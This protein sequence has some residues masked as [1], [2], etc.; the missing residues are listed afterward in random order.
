MAEADDPHVLD[1]SSCGLKKLEKRDGV[2]VHK[3]VLDH[4]ELTKLE[5]VDCFIDVQKLSATN[6]QITRMYSVGRLSQL[7]SLDLSNNLIVGIEGL[8]D[9]KHLVWTSLSNNKIKSLQNIQYSTTLVYLDLSNNSIPSLIDLTSLTRLKTLLLKKNEITTLQ[10][11]QAYLPSGLCVFSV[12]ENKI[13]DLTEVS[14]LSHLSSLESFSISGN[15]CVTLTGGI[16]GFDYRPYVINWCLGLRVLDDFVVTQRESLKAEWLYSQGKGRCFH[17]GDHLALVEYL[18][19]VCPMTTADQLESE[20]EERISRVLRM[21]RQHREQLLHEMSPG[22]TAHQQADNNNSIQGNRHP[23]HTP[24]GNRRPTTTIPRSAVGRLPSGR[25]GGKDKWGELSASE[26]EKMIGTGI[27]PFPDLLAHSDNSPVRLSSRKS[28]VASSDLTRS[29]VEARSP[30][31]IERLNDAASTGN[32][33]GSS[34]HRR[35]RRDDIM[36]R[37]VPEFRSDGSPVLHGYG[38]SSPRAIPIRKVAS[39]RREAAAAAA[40]VAPTVDQVVAASKVLENGL[41][42]SNGTSRLQNHH[43]SPSDGGLYRSSSFRN[44]GVRPAYISSPPVT[45]SPRKTQRSSS[46]TS[47]CPPYS[48]RSVPHRNMVAKPS[49]TPSFHQQTTP[50][51]SVTHWSNLNNVNNNEESEDAE[52]DRLLCK[53]SQQVGLELLERAAV[54]IQALWRGYSVRSRS[55]KVVKVCQ[56]ARLRRLEECVLSLQERVTTLND[57]VVKQQKELDE[58]RRNRTCNKDALNKLLKNMDQLESHIT[59]VLQQ[60]MLIQQQLAERAQKVQPPIESLPEGSSPRSS[61]SSDTTSTVG[62]TSTSSGVASESPAAAPRMNDEVSHDT[63]QSTNTH[64]ASVRGATGGDLSADDTSCTSLSDGDTKSLATETLDQ[65]CGD[66]AESICLSA[67][68]DRLARL[69]AVV[70]K[71]ALPKPE[72]LLGSAFQPPP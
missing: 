41:A 33:R 14:F 6:N 70:M 43:R 69:E 51:P 8:K 1:L 18:S 63:E 64:A 21:Q 29:L 27:D 3:L 59:R 39:K 23:K 49:G 67:L 22:A 17:L 54:K 66:N 44:M 24:S 10:K 19:Q 46:M 4:N 61:T 36:T 13:T 72:F 56:E 20:D 68:N 12:A 45:S 30:L 5:N 32:E 11:A 2:G 34:K 16:V 47:A 38:R 60:Q 31:T 62:A 58:E 57:T 48:P 15:P 26:D 65:S 50:P 7:A 37:S 42:V 35:S 52:V 55:E 53:R 25:H 40:V 28:D 71:L 9:L